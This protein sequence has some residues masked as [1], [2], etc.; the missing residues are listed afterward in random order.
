MC[1]FNHH[2]L[3]KDPYCIAVPVHVFQAYAISYRWQQPK[4][5]IQ[6]A[7]ELTKWL[8]CQVTSDVLSF[9]DQITFSG[10]HVG[11]VLFF[12]LKINKESFRQFQSYQ[13]FLPLHQNSQLHLGQI[14]VHGYSGDREKQGQLE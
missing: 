6:D 7:T 13:I 2:V 5:E 14:Q 8:L 1:A 3:H 12:S 11:I 4:A 10:E 9:R